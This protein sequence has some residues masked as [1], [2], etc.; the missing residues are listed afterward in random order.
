MKSEFRL[1]KTATNEAHIQQFLDEW[2]NYLNSIS[3]TI[4]TRDAISRGSLD[5]RVRGN[6]AIDMP[7]F[8][9]DMSPEAELSEE[10]KIQMQK[11]REEAMKVKR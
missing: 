2:T 7:E 11:L 9:I 6:P 4:Q 8:G 5:N 10:Q 1:H 3:S